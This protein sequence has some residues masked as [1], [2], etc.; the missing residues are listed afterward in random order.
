MD[1]EIHGILF[2]IEISSIYFI[3]NL[4]IKFKILEVVKI[5]FCVFLTFFLFKITSPIPVRE[6]CRLDDF[7]SFVSNDQKQYENKGYEIH[8]L[9]SDNK[10]YFKQYPELYNNNKAIWH[11]IDTNKGEIIQNIQKNDYVKGNK[12]AI[13]YSNAIGVDV[14]SALLLNPKARYFRTNSVGNIKMIYD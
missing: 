11:F 2:L 9:V 5:L 1:F 3:Y 4:K 14:Q 13:I 7:S 10:D 12:K 6:L 8:Y